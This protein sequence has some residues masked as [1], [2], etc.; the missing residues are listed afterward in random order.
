MNPI[1]SCQSTITD[2]VVYGR[3]AIVTRTIHVPDGLADGIVDIHLDGLPALAD[4][5]G[6]RAEI[7][8]KDRRIVAL[9]SSLTIPEQAPIPG[10]SVQR[11]EELA[12]RIERW[13][14]ERSVVQAERERLEGIQPKPPRRRALYEAPRQHLDDS[15]AAGG[16]LDDILA[17][18]DARLLDLEASLVQARKDLEAARLADSQAE[19]SQREGVGHPTRRVHLRLDGNGPVE[20]IRLMYAVAPARWWPVYT[21]RLTEK[22]SAT[23]W[24]EALV[25]Q[26]SGENWKNARLSL[27]TA[28]LIDD[29]RLPVLA[30]MRLGRAQPV[31]HRGYRLAPPDL[32]RLF[33]SFDVFISA[34]ADGGAQVPSVALGSG[35]G[36]G[37]PAMGMPLPAPPP[38]PQP[39]PAPVALME[40][41]KYIQG[42]P[43]SPA[44]DGRERAPQMPKPAFRKL[45]ANGTLR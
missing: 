36:F 41:S 34:T 10:T 1:V 12:A 24:M 16:L 4:A 20:A 22:G 25:A 14:D 40:E 32:D 15:L 6:I 2:V 44:A 18:L 26:L 9:Q 30:S 35:I 23:F 13:Q 21:L 11:V 17:R 31:E 38:S 37:M 39:S 29:I 19:S 28:G 7:A 27:C 45:Q 5:G 43:R 3:G 33:L 42:I 8:A